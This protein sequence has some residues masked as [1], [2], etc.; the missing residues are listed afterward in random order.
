MDVAQR[1]DYLTW[2]G[3]MIGAFTVYNDFYGYT[4]GVYTHTWGEVAGGHCIEVIGFDDLAGC[5]ICKN[6]WGPGFGEAGFFR[7]GYG[8]CDIDSTY[9]FWG[10]SKTEFWT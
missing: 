3:P 8:Q 10:I 1:K 6:S 5:W 4:G 2:I 7:I 9:P